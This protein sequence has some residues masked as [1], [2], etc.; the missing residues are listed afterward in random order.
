MKTGDKKEARA[1]QG[2]VQCMLD[3]LQTMMTEMMAD[4]KDLKNGQRQSEGQLRR[5]RSDFDT[6]RDNL[7]AFPL[8]SGRV[9]T[10]RVP[11]AYSSDGLLQT[12]KVEAHP[13]F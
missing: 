8:G 4:I 9:Q 2:K 10:G 1:P 11:Y 7:R 6:L 13:F 5:L 3:D 12:E